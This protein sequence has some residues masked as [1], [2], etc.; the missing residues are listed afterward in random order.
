MAKDK[1]NNKTYRPI[2][3]PELL[4]GKKES[5]Q[6]I[7]NRGSQA[8]PENVKHAEHEMQKREEAKTTQRPNLDDK[9]AERKNQLEKEKAASMSK[10][11][12]QVQNKNKE[13][14]KDR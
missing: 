10:A 12:E 13:H 6:E 1:D 9:I 2:K 11:K 14:E 5:V 7:L 8:K 4:G 3:N